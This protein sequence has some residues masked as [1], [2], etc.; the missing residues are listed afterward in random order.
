MLAEIEP[1]TANKML[2]KGGGF[3]NGNMIISDK[4]SKILGLEYK[5][6]VYKDPKILC[7]AETDHYKKQGIPQHFFV[8]ENGNMV[9]PLNTNPQWEKCKYNIVSYRLFVN[10]NT[11]EKTYHITS[12]LEKE[13]KKLDKK[14][15]GDK[16][17]DQKK[18]AEKVDKMIKE[19]KELQEMLSINSQT[20]VDLESA[21]KASNKKVKDL[22][23]ATDSAG[24]IIDEYEEEVNIYKDNLK[25]LNKKIDIQDETI[26]LLERELKEI[27]GGELLYSLNLGKLKVSIAK[28]NK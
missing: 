9:D 5:G 15:D 20:C 3:S 19:N 25:K 22:E 11:M 28:L 2:I 10:K 8:Y 23:T 26:D 12:E 27:R 14:F 6:K 7:I 18:I 13:L 24:I 4:A 21:L 16:K 17:S 1:L